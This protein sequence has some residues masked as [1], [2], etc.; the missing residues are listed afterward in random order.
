MSAEETSSL[1]D[2]D[3][4]PEDHIMEIRQ[5]RVRTS[6]MGEPVPRR[7]EK[8]QPKPAAEWTKAIVMS[9]TALACF[10]VF[11]LRRK[12]TYLARKGSDFRTYEKCD[13]SSYPLWKIDE[14]EELNM[15]NCDHLSLPDD[16]EVWSRFKSLK[17]LDLNSNSLEDLPA[18]M[19][20]LA[21]SLEI[22]FLSENKFSKVPDVIKKMN[23]LRVLSMRDNSLTELTSTNLPVSSLVWLILTNNKIAKINPNVKDL[24][25]LRKLMLSHNSLDEIPV[26][27]QQCEDLELVRLAD[28]RLEEI[29]LEVSS[30]SL[31]SPSWIALIKTS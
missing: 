19:Q 7:V 12:A 6:Q 5:R 4:M 9:I 8:K 2:E 11:T 31:G 10:M 23:K 16:E 1:F 26:E 30:A 13:L 25:H 20:V 24:I 29:P 18:A 27:L 15:S 22:L 14:A 17:K 28:N 21:P 3:S